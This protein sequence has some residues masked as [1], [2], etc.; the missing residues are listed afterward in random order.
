MRG[1]ALLLP[2]DDEA[3]SGCSEVMAL[4]NPKLPREA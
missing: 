1:L 3:V 2:E 4:A